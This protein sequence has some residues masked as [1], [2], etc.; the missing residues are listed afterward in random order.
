MRNVDAGYLNNLFQSS[1]NWL[2]ELPEMDKESISSMQ[3]HWKR[4]TFPNLEPAIECIN[5]FVDAEL[6]FMT[7]GERGLGRASTYYPRLAAYERKKISRLG[8]QEHEILS[9]RIFD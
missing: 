9:T 8:M 1:S 4:T 5:R 3:E 6:D 7:P 2:R